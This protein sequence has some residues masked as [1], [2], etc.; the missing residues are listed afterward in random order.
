MKKVKLLEN[1]TYMR[2]NSFV[3]NW[4]SWLMSLPCVPFF[5]WVSVL[6][7]IGLL[8]FFNLLLF[9]SK[10][11][12]VIAFSVRLETTF[13]AEC[14]LFKLVKFFLQVQRSLAN[15]LLNV[16][17]FWANLIYHL[18]DAENLWFYHVKSFNK[19][20]KLVLSKW[21][22]ILNS[23]QLWWLLRHFSGLSTEQFL[24][25]CLFFLLFEFVLD[26]VAFEFL[27]KLG[28]NLLDFPYLL[29]CFF[30]ILLSIGVFA[31]VRLL[32]YSL[33]SILG[34]KINDWVFRRSKHFPCHVLFIK[35]GQNVQNQ[36]CLC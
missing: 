11:V 22:L 26:L 10:V 31:R 7:F 2:D 9:I 33:R 14:V 30:Q 21:F 5:F 8:S 3:D 12:Y 36:F 35:R 15:L 18:I 17:L 4:K 6:L 27:R 24:F 19:V 34:G 1:I 20:C 25:I 23:D 29:P 13:F 16:V 28:H 32:L